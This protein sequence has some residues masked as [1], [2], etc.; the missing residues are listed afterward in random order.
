MILFPV[1]YMIL[2]LILWIVFT[3]IAKSVNPQTV[4]I[5]GLDVMVG[6]V[7]AVVWPLTLVISLVSAIGRLGR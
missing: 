7:G 3:N 2:F 5:S 4:H 6:F 1:F